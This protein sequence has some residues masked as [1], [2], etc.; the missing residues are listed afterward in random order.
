MPGAHGARRARRRPARGD[1]AARSRW[2]RPGDVVVIAGKGHEQGQEFAGGRKE[3]FDDVAVAREAL[4]AV[5]GMR[6]LERRARSPRPPA[7]DAR[8]RGAGGRA[9]AGGDRLARGRPGR[10]V[11][12]PRRAS[13]S[14]AARSPPARWRRA[15]GA[16]SSRPEHAAGCSAAA[17]CWPRSDPLAALRRARA[18]VAARARRRRDRRHRL[19]RQ[20][21]DQGPDRG[22]DRAAPARASPAAANFNT[23]IGLPLEVLARARRHRG[24]GARDGHARASAQIAELAAIAEP[25]VGV[26]TDDR[27]GP[28]RAGRLAG[29]VARAKAELL[30]RRRASRSCPAGEPLLEPCL[31]A[32]LEVVRFG[33]GGDVDSSRRCASASALVELPFTVARTSARNTLAAVAAARAVGVRA[34]G[35]RRR[36][37][38]G[39]A[40]RA[41][42]SCRAASRSSTTATTPTRCRCAPPWTISP[43]RRPAGRRV[44]V[45]GDMLELGPERA[46]AAPRD[47]RVRGRAPASTCWS[48]S[49]R[50]AAAML[51]PRS[52]ARLATRSPDAAEA[53]A[54]GRRARRS[55][56]TSCW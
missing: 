35:P 27:P 22:A 5:V 3:P 6:A 43:R 23:E 40:R 44:A 4:R 20:D 45:L 28:P 52:T 36:R 53:A 14:T 50:V 42:R 1:R 11:R 51:R 12:R 49:G 47:R 33:P 15:R 13:A 7:R 9:R 55:P 34:G 32:A 10:P 2:P 39:A 46:R 56:A 38:V 19:G 41:R 37:A 25:D 8:A 31:R 29:G 30:A 16:C 54:A 48:P 24:A 21:L 17:P 26:I 18:R